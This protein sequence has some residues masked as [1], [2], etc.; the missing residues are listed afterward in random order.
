MCPKC[1]VDQL[2]GVLEIYMADY[3]LFYRPAR[4]RTALTL[5]GEAKTMSHSH[6]GMIPAE[7]AAE[8]ALDHGHD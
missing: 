5:I 6:D 7:Q 8:V 1:L 3:N 4:V 2:V